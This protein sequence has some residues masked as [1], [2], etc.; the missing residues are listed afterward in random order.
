MKQIYHNELWGRRRR[1]LVAALACIVKSS[2]R[3]LT[4]TLTP[5]SC[6]A[7]YLPLLDLA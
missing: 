1:R 6:L 5:K 3:T 2:V 4:L 7:I